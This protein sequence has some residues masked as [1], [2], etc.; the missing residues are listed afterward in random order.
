MYKEGLQDALVGTHLQASCWRECQR[1]YEEE[2]GHKRAIAV[3]WLIKIMFAI[4]NR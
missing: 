2:I 1:N 4:T 3:F